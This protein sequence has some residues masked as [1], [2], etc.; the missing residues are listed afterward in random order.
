MSSVPPHANQRASPA[1]PIVTAKRARIEVAK[2]AAS[3]KLTP[4]LPVGALGQLV[5]LPSDR[6]L[7][8]SLD[9]VGKLHGGWGTVIFSVEDAVALS[10]VSIGEMEKATA[11]SLSV[12][13]ALPSRILRERFLKGAEDVLIRTCEAAAHQVVMAREALSV[14]SDLASQACLVM[15][16]AVLESGK[17]AAVICRVH[18]FSQKGEAA[19]IAALQA[20]GLLRSIASLRTDKRMIRSR[21]GKVAAFVELLAA[22]EGGID[23]AECS[24]RL[25]NH[26]RETLECDTVALSVNHWGKQRLAAVSGEAGPVEA[27]SPGRRALLTHLSE[28]V[29]RGQPLLSRR[30]PP[31]AP[32]QSAGTPGLREWFDPAVAYC[33]PLID[34]SGKPRGGWLFLWNAEPDGFEEKQSLIKAASPEVAPLLA[35]LKKAKPGAALGG[36]LRLWKKGSQFQRRTAIVAAAAVIIAM[37]IPLPYPVG[38]TCE[39]QPVVRRVIAAPFDGILQRSAAKAGELVEEGQ[40]LAEMDGRELRSQL[41]EA[42]AQR[43]RALKESDTATAAGRIAEGRIAAL[44]AEGLGHQIELLEYRQR[45]LEVRSPIAGLVLQGDLERS[46]GAPLR[47]GDTLFENGPLDRLVAEVAVPAKDVSLVAAGAKVK[48]KLESHVNGTAESVLLRVAPKSEWIEDRNVFICEAEI[49]NPDGALR[50]GL[51]G[52]AKVEGPSR[53]LLWIL[54][55]D[56]WLALRY[57]FW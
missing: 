45:H 40:L 12:D 36:F 25:A 17:V 55:R 39:L 51:K 48:L 24:R 56:A 2:P 23:F 30:Q 1:G 10:P 20:L 35:L 9:V 13:G 7:P 33:L 31:G 52:K 32:G 44:E 49:E 3:R 21:F 8:V 34:A 38:A 6:I 53:P 11:Y 19:P 4:A 5:D 29:H 37:F 41:A 47:V 42:L 18:D 54:C 15:A 16:V 27:H 22:S 14:P 26:L 57:H 46:E 50:A 28:S 43:E